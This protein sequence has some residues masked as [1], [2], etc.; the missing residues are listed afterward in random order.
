[1][2]SEVQDISLGNTARIN[3]ELHPLSPHEECDSQ[4]GLNIQVLG[5]LRSNRCEEDRCLAFVKGGKKV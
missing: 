2:C 3:P 4:H 5:T 1:M